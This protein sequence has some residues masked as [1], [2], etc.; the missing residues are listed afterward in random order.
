[1]KFEVTAKLTK[2]IDEMRYLT[3]ENAWRYRS[4]LRFFYSQSEKMKNWLYKEEVFAALK[5][6]DEFVNYTL[7]QCKQDLDVLLSWKNLSAYQDTAKVATVEEFK[8]KQFRYQMTP[9]S[10]E[11]ER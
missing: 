7:E 8:N 2:Q 10:V 9:Y 5:E 1:M 4:I 6:Y 3:A 11:I